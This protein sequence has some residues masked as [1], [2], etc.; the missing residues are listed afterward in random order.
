MNIEKTRKIVKKYFEDKVDKGNN[1]YMEHLEYVS[2]HGRNET[3][4]IVG[5]LHDILEDTHLT[6]TDLLD[7]G[8]S[9]EIV[10]TVFLLTHSKN[11]SYNEYIERIIKSK[12]KM[13]MYIKKIDMEHNMD[14]TRL[15]N[16]TE[17]D[18]KRVNEKYKPNYLKIVKALEEEN[19]SI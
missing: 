5:L 18:I 4:K 19:E 11:L 6:R 2:F 9:S 10:D 13:A 15:K 8:F 14:L 12:N 7:M 16:K 3:E 17:K 1:P